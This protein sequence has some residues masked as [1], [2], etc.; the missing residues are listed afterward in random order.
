[1]RVFIPGDSREFQHY[2]SGSWEPT[3]GFALTPALLDIAPHEDPDDL[4][5]LAKDAATIASITEHAS[6]LRLVVVADYPRADAT[7]IAGEH[8]AAVQLTGKVIT[9]AIACFFVDEPQAAAD[10]AAAVSDPEALESLRS[11]DVL[12]YDAS[13]AEVLSELLESMQSGG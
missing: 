3:R 8:P 1:M 6:P 2:L 13:E 12:W 10:C 5:E 7:P 11:R 4:A 9:S